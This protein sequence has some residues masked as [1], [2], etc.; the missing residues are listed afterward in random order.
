M[1]SILSAARRPVLIA[2]AVLAAWASAAAADSLSK[3]QV[4]ARVMGYLSAI[5]DACG[6][7]RFE[8]L[9]DKQALGRF[10]QE[11]GA[12]QQDWMPGGQYYSQGQ[13]GEAEGKADAAK[14]GFC[15]RP[16]SFRKPGGYDLSALLAPAPARP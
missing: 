6:Q 8:T 14:P 7:E 10:T 13:Q 9:I 12:A 15:D 11:H 16:A 3:P 2:V 5:F 4:G 1:R